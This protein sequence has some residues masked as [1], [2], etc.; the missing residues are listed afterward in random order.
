MSTDERTVWNTT[1]AIHFAE[2]RSG[3]GTALQAY[4]V[5]AAIKADTAVE[6]LRSE[7]AQR[8]KP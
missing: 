3:G 1:F 2:A 7:M 5:S 6:H 8:S 4:A